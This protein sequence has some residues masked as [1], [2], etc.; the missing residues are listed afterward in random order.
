M[1]DPLRQF[2]ADT[3]ARFGRSLRSPRELFNQH[4]TA[5]QSLDSAVIGGYG[6]RDILAG[7]VHESQI[8]PL[9]IKAFHSQYPHTGDFVDF[10]RDHKGDA[11][12]LGIINGIKGKAFELEYLNYLNHGHLPTGAVAELAH[13]PTQE[14]WDIAIRDAD[15]SIIEHLQLKATESLSYIKDAIAHHPDIDVVVTHEVFEHM[16]DPEVLSHL[17]DSGIS[18]DHLEHIAS[19]AVHDVSPDFGFIPLAAF[20]IIALQ[21]WQRYRKGAPLTE[22]VRQASRRASYSLVSRGAAYFATLLMHQPFV[23][24]ASGILIRLGLSRY[25]A[26]REF[27]EFVLDCRNQ[28][29]SRLEIIQRQCVQFTLTL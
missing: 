28:Q 11:S 16:N 5:D 4:L 19:T 15:G 22:V 20:G 1:N 25:D 21:S 7:K 12:L 8:S 6:V 3:N 17:I 2:V 10:V 18:N 27:L 26:Q 14:G 23:G 29:N 13:S 9:V 24:T